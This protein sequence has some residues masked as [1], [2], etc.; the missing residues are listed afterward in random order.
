MAF[1]VLYSFTLVHPET[2]AARIAYQNADKAFREME[3]K[4]AL[5]KQELARLFNPE[6]YGSEGEWRKLKD[7]CLKTDV[8]E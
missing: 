2:T 6:Y 5:D 3:T 8:G 1:A 7:T 4:L